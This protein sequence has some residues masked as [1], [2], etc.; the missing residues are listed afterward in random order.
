MTGC[1][2]VN[3]WREH[4]A[5]AAR[6]FPT[7]SRSTGLMALLGG[8]KRHATRSRRQIRLEFA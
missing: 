3:S 7:T 6:M 2:T 8:S 4:Y 1:G 5:L